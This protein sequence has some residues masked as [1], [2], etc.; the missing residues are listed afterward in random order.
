MLSEHMQQLIFNLAKKTLSKLIF[1][2]MST[3]ILMKGERKLDRVD[4]KL[5]K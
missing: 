4:Y 5:M 1:L 2:E 3:P